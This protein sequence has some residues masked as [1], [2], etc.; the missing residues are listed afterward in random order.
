MPP[1]KENGRCYICLSN[2]EIIKV[3][4]LICGLVNGRHDLSLSCQETPG[5]NATPVLCNQLYLYCWVCA[6]W[7]VRYTDNFTSIV[8][9]RVLCWRQM[10]QS[11][12]VELWM[13]LSIGGPLRTFACAWRVLIWCPGSLNIKREY[14]VFSSGCEG[15]IVS[16]GLQH[17]NCLMP[18]NTSVTH[19][20]SRWLQHA[21]IRNDKHSVRNI[22]SNG[23]MLKSCTPFSQPQWPPGTGWESLF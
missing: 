4:V 7:M 13:Y 18:I 3:Y 23:L 10:L 15:Q 12:A 1:W 2:K 14:T 6:V 19:R 16:V 9:M 8:F 5:L 22:K 11:S 21:P 17:I 20:S